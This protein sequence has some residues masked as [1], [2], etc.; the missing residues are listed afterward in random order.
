[1]ELKPLAEQNDAHLS[2]VMSLAQVEAPVRA[3]PET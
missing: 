1:M 2:M 3:R